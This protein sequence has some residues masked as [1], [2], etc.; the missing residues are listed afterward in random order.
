MSSFV[1]DL[2]PIY[3]SCHFELDRALRRKKLSVNRN[4]NVNDF[5][6]DLEDDDE[7]GEEYLDKEAREEDVEKG[8]KGREE[9]METNRVF[10]DVL[11]IV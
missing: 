6:I 1:E 8:I 3:R 10:K 5:R 9:F 7:I 4:E 11:F 2:I